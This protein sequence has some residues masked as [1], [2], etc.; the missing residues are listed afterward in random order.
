MDNRDR[1]FDPTYTAGPYYPNV[2]PMNRVWHRVRYGGETVDL[3]KGYV[4]SWPQ[5]WPSK[6]YDAVA[7]VTAVDEFKVL[8]L[9]N[10]A[11]TDPPSNSYADVVAFDA[12]TAYWPMSGD[13]AAAEEAGNPGPS[14][15]TGLAG[16]SADLAGLII[17]D[18]TPGYQAARLVATPLGTQWDVDNAPTGVD[19]GGLSEITAE[20]WFSF[21]AAPAS[22]LSLVSG[23]ATDGSHVQ[24]RFA[25]NTSAQVEFTATMDVSGTPTPATVTSLALTPGAVYHLVAAIE[26][27]TLKLYVNGLVVDSAAVSG[28]IESIS[29]AQGTFFVGDALADHDLV[30]DEIAVYRT[31]LTIDRIT[32]HY[33]AGTA[34]GFAYGQAPGER[35]GAILDAAGPNHAP[36]DLQA[37]QR[38]MTGRYMTGQDPLSEMR[39]AEA[40]EAVDAVLF[41][42]RD[43]KVKFLDSAHRASAPYDSPVITLADDGTGDTGYFD[44]AVD[45]SD[46]YL[47]NKW[48]V[49]GPG[50]R[51]RPRRT[52]HRS[53]ATCSARSR[54]PSS[55]S[56]TTA[57]RPT[58][59]T[60]C[61][62][63]TRSRS[64]ASPRSCPTRPTPPHA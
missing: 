51:R 15:F 52:T 31:A 45:Y 43:G 54:S 47:A 23:S 13:P 33:A 2:T 3:F 6:G 40:A 62:P 36:R 4:E 12:P 29:N 64:C 21:E 59:P 42:G 61:S 25:Q 34:R 17:G 63:S 35:L 9:D 11:V 44:I 37:G 32:A 41:V 56:P 50:A 7:N 38:T 55:P 48:D 10:L 5:E 58:S 60:T 46:S 1:R 8:A 20:F 18:E 30:F 19:L 39:V 27:G 26:S 22:A 57:T 28:V 49:T 53:R 24:Y 16:V 14:L